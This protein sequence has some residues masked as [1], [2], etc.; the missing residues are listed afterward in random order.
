[1]NDHF[2]EDDSIKIENITQKDLLSFAKFILALNGFMFF[3][4]GV[5]ELFISGNQFFEVCRTALPPFS[6]IIT[7]YY[8]G[9]H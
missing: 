2:H 3:I 7:G 5:S 8:F 9:K 1:M 4:A 6:G